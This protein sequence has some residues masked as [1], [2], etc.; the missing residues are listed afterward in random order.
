MRLYFCH[1]LLSGALMAQMAQITGRVTDTS[2]AVVPG[3]LIEVTNLGTGTQRSIR[4][5]AEGYYTIP[6]LQPGRYRLAVQK[7]GFRPVVRDGV[8]LAVDQVARLDFALQV[9]TLAESINVSAEAPL[10]DSSGATVGTVIENKRVSELPLNGRNALALVLLTPGVKSNAGPTNS[11]FG[12]RGIGLS[13]VSINGGPSGMNNLMLDGGNNV[14]A[15]QGGVNI[16]P[17][18]DSVQ[19][20]KVQANTMSA[21]YG[22]TAGGVVNMVTK[23]GGNQFHGTLY[24]FLRNDKLDARNAFAV[25]REP[26]RYNQFGGAVGGPVLLPKLYNG[27]DRTFFFFNYEEWRYRR[28]D[29]PIFSVPTADWRAGDFSQLRNANGNLIPVFD[30]A[31]TRQNPSGSGFIR[32]AFPGNIMPSNRIDPV[33]K[34]ILPFYPLPNRAPINAF[35]QAN[36][37]I[38]RNAEARSMRQ[39]MIRG[40]HRVSNRN[41]LFGRYSYYKH[42]TDGGTGGVYPDPVVRQRLDTWENHNAILSDTH[43]VTPSII[44][45][46]RVGL[47]RLRFPF[48][49]ASFGGDWPEKLGLP[50][51]VPRDTFPAVSNGFPGFVTGTAGLRSSTVWQL[52]DSL[53]MIRGAHTM[54]FG[55]ELRIN[56][57]NNLQRSSPS[58]SF[59]FPATL[60]GN[61]QVPAG[62]GY[63]F[64]TFLLGAVGNANV[65]THLGQAQHGYSASFF[66]QDDWKVTSALTVNFGLRYDYQPWAVERYNRVSSFDP[67]EVDP[68]SNL[69]GRQEYAGID[70]GRSAAA[71]IH[72][73]FGPRFGFAYDVFGTG[74]T[75]VR[76]GY[77]IFYPLIFAR[78][79]FGGGNG[80]ATTSTAYLPPGGNAN[81]AAFQFS[82]GFPS[83]PI[84]PQ[85]A[86]LG[87]S[88]FLG[89]NA[90]YSEPFDKVPMAQQWNLGIQRQFGGNWMVEAT[91]SGAHGTHFLSG[92]YDLNQLDPRYLGLGL[93]LQDRVPNPY[94]GIVPGSLGAA[95]ITREQSLRPY[96]YYN[97]IIVTNP[98]NGNYNSHALLL[99][100][101]KRFARGL[102]LLASFTG[103]KL[104]SDSVRTM[105]D[106]GSTVEQVN[107]VNYQ[108][109]AFDRRSERGL[110]PTDVAKRLVV[111][112]VYE[113][114]FGAGRAYKSGSTFVNGLIGGWQINA[115]MTAQSGVPLVIRGA[116]NFRADRPNSTG[117]SAK[118]DNPSASRWFDTSAFVNPPSYTLGNVGRVLPDVRAPGV[119]NMDISVLKD[120]RIAEGLRLEFRLEAFNAFNTVNLGF[121]NTTFSP[122]PD[123][124]NQSATFAVIN[125]ARDARIMQVGLKLIF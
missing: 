73:N 78:D 38:A 64:T 87:P 76:G 109:G 63:G 51:I 41:T 125:S 96:P 8:G 80:F 28:Y 19:E 71:N 18:V 72:T 120:T 6:L 89:Q 115:I 75:V 9:G 29:N 16:N 21:E 116:N 70:Y 99:S 11:G 50:P 117:A 119:F 79:Y 112:G 59:T 97:Q 103:G 52:T 77:G 54:K 35:T 81:L 23:S 2:D 26:F 69:L 5:N 101:Q 25:Q 67:F 90:N 66:A 4:S 12:D 92:N 45:E 94:A 33:S 114:P 48:N 34:N 111:S 83:A 42:F 39:Y 24:E 107:I 14:E 100:M 88:A 93:S 22:F 105:F 55:T 3:A 47:V 13:S 123:G 56:R 1:F 36:N 32:D 46:L 118:L 44:N 49:V 10:V 108:N 20:F 86:L 65:T 53:T 82:T 62:T 7:E 30:P 85:G 91:Y 57:T 61:P 68:V 37:F 43:T 40:D 106:F 122:G 121:P 58:G 60:T 104:I 27:K 15:Y 113:L 84:Q 74:K 98:R 31:S 110:D 95:T 17:A 102:T 124:R